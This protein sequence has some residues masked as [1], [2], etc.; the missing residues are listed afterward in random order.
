M[1]TIHA[2]TAAA[3][4][5][6]EPPGM[7]SGA[8]GFI[9]A[10]EVGIV[11]GDAVGELVQ[12]W[13]VPRRPRRRASTARPPR[14]RACRS[15]DRWTGCLRSRACLPRASRPLPPPPR[16]REDRA[17]RSGAWAG[18][19]RSGAW[20]GPQGAER[21]PGLP[22]AERGPG[23]QG[24]SLGRAPKGGAGDGAWQRVGS[25]VKAFRSERCRARS[26]APRRPIDAGTR[27][28]APSA[29]NGETRARRVRGTRGV[30]AARKSSSSGRLTWRRCAQAAARS[31]WP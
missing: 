20:A 22:G 13:R 29:G 10:P 12:V 5:P 6:L 16:P 14:R 25:Q 27:S 9:N 1:S 21:G 28:G 31:P 15:R 11:A 18:A 8:T 19:P 23:P 26:S 4:P 30:G 24:R 3:E 17:P 2:A 7:R